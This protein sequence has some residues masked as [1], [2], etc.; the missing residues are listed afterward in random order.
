MSTSRVAFVGLLLGGRVATAAADEYSLHLTGQMQAAATDNLLSAPEDSVPPEPEYVSDIQY[1]F[2]P[3][4]LLTYATGRAVFQGSY[5]LEANLYQK[6]D[7]A[8][9][10][11]HSFGIDG[12]FLTSPRTELTTNLRYQTGV[13]SSFAT[14]TMAADGEFVL[15]PSGNS[16]FQS[17]EINEILAF[18]ATR[19]M[20]LSEN[21]RYR[22]FSTTDLSSDVHT[23]GEG[24]ELMLST[25]ADRG[26]RESAISLMT[27]ASLSI[28]GGHDDVT[29]DTGTTKQINANAIASYRRD[30]GPRWTA[31]GD[32]GLTAIIP[33]DVVIPS[34]QP[35]VGVQLG[36]FPLWGSAGASLRRSVAPNLTVRQ[37]TINDTANVH[38]SLPLP[39]LADDP[40]Q[41]KLTVGASAAAS[42][43]QLLDLDTGDPTGEY[44]VYGGDL[45]VSYQLMEGALASLRYQYINQSVGEVG[46]VEGET[47]VVF[48]YTRNTLMLSVGGRFPNRLAAEMPQRDSLRV[49]RSD[50]TPVGEELPA[51]Q[52]PGA[53]Q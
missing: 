38:L 16:E 51:R 14:E 46:M 7:D 37:N 23:V 1:Q 4:A 47:P 29:E 30:L 27:G 3:G 9:S 48:D 50:A 8:S 42:R 32:F 33:L 18:T 53:P 12:F 40:A 5:Q 24:Q 36:Y 22:R 10:L 49:D 26:F 21:F 45:A 43:T 15:S 2:Q 13:L 6:R 41:P 31:M 35:T 34:Y 44:Y 20:R 25:T 39:W 11:Q 19:E 52:A 17:A 28:M